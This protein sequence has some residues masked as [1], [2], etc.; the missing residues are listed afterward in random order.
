MALN[1]IAGRSYNDLSQYPVFPWVIC[2]YKSKWLDLKD[3]RVYRDLSRPIGALNEKRLSHFIERYESFEDPTGRIKKFHYGTHYSSASAVAYYLLRL[4]PFTSVHVSLQSGKFD[5]ADRQFYSI[6]ET[7]NSCMTGPGDVKELIPE[8][9]YL[10]E[11]LVNSNGVDLG[12]KQDGTLLGDV[13][14]P[15]WASTPDEFVQ[16]HRQALESEYVSANLHKWI[17]LVF[18][19]KQRGHEAIKAHNVFYYLTYEGAV[20][21]DA[22]QDPVE[23]ASVESQIH[24]FGQTPTQL[25]SSPHPPRHTPIARPLYSPL[26]NPGGKVQHFI[27]RASNSNITF[28]GSS[29]DYKFQL[30]VEPFVEGFYMLAA[31]SPPSECQ[32]LA[33]A[34]QRPV[35][36]AVLPNLPELIVSAVHFD[37]TLKC[38]RL[39]RNRESAPAET[40]VQASLVR[41]T[42]LSAST[43]MSMTNAYAS[44]VVGAMSRETRELGERSSRVGD[45]S[46]TSSATSKRNTKESNVRSQ[47]SSSRTFSGILASIGGNV[48][49]SG[50]AKSGREHSNIEVH[51]DKSGISAPPSV[52]IPLASRLL[53]TISAFSDIPLPG[54]QMCVAADGCGGSRVAVGSS[55]GSICILNIGVSTERT[56][57][58]TAAAIAATAMFGSDFATSGMERTSAMAPLLFAT[59]M[60][61]PMDV[62]IGHTSMAA[63]ASS[64]SSPS[65]LFG[66]GRSAIGGGIAGGSSGGSASGSNA[67]GYYNSS[68]G[69]GKAGSWTLQH[70]L[71]GHDAAVL[72]V[73]VDSDHDVVAGASADG[74]VSLWTV[75]TGRYLRSLVPVCPSI[76]H[77]DDA[78][79]TI[80][81]HQNRYA[82]VE[83]V[84]ISSEALAICYSVSGALGADDSRDRLD[85]TRAFNQT[86]LTMPGQS[87]GSESGSLS[88]SHSASSQDRYSHYYN[89]QKSNV[90]DDSSCHEGKAADDNN[91]QGSPIDDGAFEIAALHVYTI[92]GRHLRTRKL[93]HHLRDI[94]LTKDGKYGVCVNLNSRVAIFET[95]TLSIVRQ[96]ELPACGCSVSWSGASERQI[97]VGC[98]G[99]LVVVISADLSVVH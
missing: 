43:T 86:F 8:F 90:S 53:D 59:G 83:R 89:S 78:I 13:S 42:P 5:H 21:L 46:T 34:D 98:E 26:T 71:H 24:Y 56:S 14:L 55:D 4:E 45:K 2:D 49:G 25:F 48:G 36:Y 20:N 15:P 7:W 10:P 96:F 19:Y 9:F 84:L 54:Q 40:T 95:N 27:L 3:P 75:R 85:P 58:S 1:T 6:A 33:L 82:R 66:E 91:P 81:C 80:A 44:A 93:V 17:D 37:N 39:T 29:H 52:F 65:A 99:G 94:A 79:P 16:I 51:D 74:T 92:N 76:A 22:I 64:T 69:D 23:R 73:A 88:N 61:N 50:A 70:V 30:T 60:G 57:G 77:P 31:S 62:A 97:I 18:G 87:L 28:V 47:T 63:Y 68:V 12:K 67:G 35:A 11:F 41:N 38:A 72:D 32:R